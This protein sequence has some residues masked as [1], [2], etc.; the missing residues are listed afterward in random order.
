MS[1]DD[2]PSS[3]HMKKVKSFKHAGTNPKEPHTLDHK[4]MV[5]FEDEIEDGVEAVEDLFKAGVITND[6]REKL[7]DFQEVDEKDFKSTFYGDNSKQQYISFRPPHH[8][9][10]RPTSS[11]N[12]RKFVKRLCFITFTHFSC[13]Q[14][15]CS[16]TVLG[17]PSYLSR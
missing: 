1:T 16:D 4:S 2:E 11:F 17:T 3:D 10:L 8:V 6:S 14:L 13:L 12:L 9:D 15:I 5:K 7:I